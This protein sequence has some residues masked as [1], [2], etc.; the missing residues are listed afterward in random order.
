M[1]PKMP[2]L[3]G[4]GGETLEADKYAHYNVD[5]SSVEELEWF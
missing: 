3:L 1:A 5:L 2:V 4:N